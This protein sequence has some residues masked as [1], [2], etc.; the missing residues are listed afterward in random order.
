MIIAAILFGVKYHVSGLALG[1]GASTH[2][3]WNW[4]NSIT[5]KATAFFALE[6]EADLVNFLKDQH[7]RKSLLRPVGN[8]HD[9]GHGFG[10]LTTCVNEGETDRDS[11]ILSLT[12]LAH[13]EIGGNNTVTFGA[14][15]ELLGLLP[16][17][18]EHGLQVHNLG[19]QN[20]QNY[21]GAL[22]TGTHGTGK[23]HKN[24]ATQII[25]MR[26]LDTQGNI[27]TINKDN[28]PDLLK[29]FTISIGALGIIIEPTILGPHLD[30]SHEKHELVLIPEA[31]LVS[32]E[33]TDYNAHFSPIEHLANIDVDYFNYAKLQSPHL[34]PYMNADLDSGAD[35][36]YLSDDMTMPNYNEFPLQ[37]FHQELA[38][39]FVPRFREEYNIR[40]HWNKILWN[41]ATSSAAIYPKLSEWLDVQEVIDPN[42]QFVNPILV[43][44]AGL[45][46]CSGL[47]A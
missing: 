16:I 46:R 26:V 36:G 32:W 25:A 40:P 27:H 33:E 12:N 19:S 5:C 44:S 13:N 30:W 17:L 18:R 23:M 39:E 20:I 41:N 31:I 38:S 29:A 28:N 6:I 10:D 15:W 1:Q 7:L 34:A 43:E 11:Y 35:T 45:D 24:L 2:R 4:T 37:W 9:F 21:V 8:D 22:T 47:F 14:G 42:C 3:W